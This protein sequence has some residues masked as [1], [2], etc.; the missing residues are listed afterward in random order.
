MDH[1]KTL[2]SRG[3]H[4]GSIC[5][6]AL[7]ELKTIKKNGILEIILD[8]KM[9]I[10]DALKVWSKF[11]GHKFSDSVSESNLIRVFIKKGIN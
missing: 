8:N 11:H 3:K 6:L 1:F 4:F 9:N 5:N 2:D 10:L 7:V